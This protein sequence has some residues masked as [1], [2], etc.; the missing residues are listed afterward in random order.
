M[1][2]SIPGFRVLSYLLEEFAE[3]ESYVYTNAV[4]TCSMG[5]I[6]ICTSSLCLEQFSNIQISV[7]PKLTKHN[8]VVLKINPF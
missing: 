4:V 3:C 8:T 1:D 2:C 5:G 6:H 7:L